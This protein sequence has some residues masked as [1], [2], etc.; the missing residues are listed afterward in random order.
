MTAHAQQSITLQM[1]VGTRGPTSNV[2]LVCFKVLVLLVQHQ[3][4]L[5]LT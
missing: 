2:A 3:R 4:Y 5:S 1:G